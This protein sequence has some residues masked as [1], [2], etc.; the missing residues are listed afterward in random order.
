[1]YG[2]IDA[3]T[4]MQ[5]V[6]KVQTGNLQAVVYDLEVSVGFNLSCKYYYFS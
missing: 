1:M 6:G 3:A 2:K 4:V 5:S